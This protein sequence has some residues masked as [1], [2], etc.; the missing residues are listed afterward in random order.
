MEIYKP[1]RTALRVAMRRAVH[2]LVDRPKVLDDPFAIPIL[3][4]EKAAELEAE[5]AKSGQSI[6]RSMRAFM[7]VRSRYAEDELA[8]AVA[9]GV[10]Q[11][12]VLGAGLDTFAYR[13]IFR[14]VGLRVFEV[15]HPATQAWKRRRLEAAK[16]TIPPE[17]T[18]VA[19]DFEKQRLP[20]AL[21]AA[22][23]RQDEPAFFS[24]LGVV[25]YLTAGAFKETL[26]F[27]A[28][29]SPQ[30]GVVFDYGVARSKLNFLEKLALDAI[31]ARVAAAG[32]PFILFFEPEELGD[33]LRQNFQ[34]FEDLSNDEINARYF[35]HRNDRL[36][37]RGGLGRLVSA[38]V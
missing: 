11:Y 32:E 18:F 10:R 8:Q 3:G 1:S 29:L 5:T 6:A 22:G 15:D 26:S 31:S 34:S 28:S 38:R 12:V 20:D 13:N 30:S 4:V 2:Q 24:W 9:R 36:C 35:S 19:V 27:I 7:A 37:V 33:L 14:D 21:H 17:A 25:P 23:F 16:I